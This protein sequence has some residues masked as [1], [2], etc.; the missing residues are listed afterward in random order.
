[1]ASYTVGLDLGQAQDYSALVT[2]EHGG[3]RHDAVDI[4]RWPLGTPYPVIVADVGAM[5]DAPPLVGASLVVDGTGV[6][7]GIIDMFRT[8]NRRPV[9]VLITAGAHAH[10]DENGYWLVPKKE[11]VG[12]VQL[13]L[14]TGVLKIA[15]SLPHAQTI[16]QELTQFQAK[17]TDAANVVTGAW[18]E[19][20]HDDLVLALALALWWVPRTNSL[21][22]AFAR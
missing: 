3:G 13:A 11:L 6:G 15:R 12:A 1:V 4:R 22:G 9:P 19:G 7:R 14:Q 5:L 10:E 18:R 8:A 17:I 16:A 20:Q 2:L 21:V